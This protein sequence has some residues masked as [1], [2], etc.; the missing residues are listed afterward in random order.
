MKTMKRILVALLIV[1]MMLT[2]VACGA[3]QTVTLQAD[4]SESGMSMTD[5]MVL[6]AKGDTVQELKEI[7]VLDISTYDEETKDY[8]ISLLNE[9]YVVPAHA[10]NGVTCTDSTTD[11]SYTIELTVDCTNSSAIKEAAAAG[12]LDVSDTSAG[13]ISLKATQSGLEANGYTVVE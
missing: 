2:A 13:R 5:T 3:E 4:L 1:G 11:S 8:L 9:S 12:I 6:N 7:M 10:I